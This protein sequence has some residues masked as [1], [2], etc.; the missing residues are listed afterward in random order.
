MD[1]LRTEAAESDGS[2]LS[3]SS[4]HSLGNEVGQQGNILGVDVLA[5]FGRGTL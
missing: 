1:R 5:S 2:I 4:A 3:V